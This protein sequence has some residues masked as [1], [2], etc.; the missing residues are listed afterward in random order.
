MTAVHEVATECRKVLE[1]YY[2][3]RFKGLLLYGSM[4]REQESSTSDIDF[5]VLLSSPFD[6]FQELRQIIEITYSIQMEV[7][8]LLS[9][10]PAL[11]DEFENGSIQLYRNI[12]KEGIFC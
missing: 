6:Y 3:D 7:D 11:L 10:K 4:A 2:G 8:N 9:I 1:H 12:Q 5:L